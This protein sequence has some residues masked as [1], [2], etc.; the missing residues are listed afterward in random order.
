[1]PDAEDLW[2]PPLFPSRF[3]PLKFLRDGDV[4]LED[5]ERYFDNYEDVSLRFR[6]G[7]GMPKENGIEM[8]PHQGYGSYPRECKWCK[9][10][11]DH[12]ML[13]C[14]VRRLQ[15]L[16]TALKGG[17]APDEHVNAIDLWH[18]TQEQRKHAKQMETR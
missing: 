5:W 15:A 3:D 13:D 6:W 12:T 14:P 9:D 1:M 8:L 11:I 7:E 10:Q 16:A 17:E 2:T 4:S 18:P